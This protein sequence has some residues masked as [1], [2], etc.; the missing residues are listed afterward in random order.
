MTIIL[1]AA[2]IIGLIA[3]LGA[4]IAWAAGSDES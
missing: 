2:A 1:T 4:I 3:T